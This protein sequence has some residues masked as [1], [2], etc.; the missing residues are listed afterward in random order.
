MTFNDAYAALSK[1]VAEIEDDS[2]KLDSLAVKIREANQLIAFC[3]T[4]LRVVE[5]D[6]AGALGAAGPD[7]MEVGE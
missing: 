5:D 7:S 4:Q 1:L 2:I 3:E 6:V